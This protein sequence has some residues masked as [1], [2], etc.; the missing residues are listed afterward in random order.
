LGYSTTGGDVDMGWLLR[1]WAQNGFVD[2][3]SFVSE[4]NELADNL[5]TGEEETEYPMT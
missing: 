2:L 3:K 1:C 4:F 5:T